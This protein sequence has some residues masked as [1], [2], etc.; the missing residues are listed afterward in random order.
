VVV[1]AVPAEFVF[2]LLPAQLPPLF[3]L[4]VVAPFVSQ[5]FVAAFAQLANAR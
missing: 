3:P 4:P 5:Y 2:Q 1:A